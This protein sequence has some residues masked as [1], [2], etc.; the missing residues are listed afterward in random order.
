MKIQWDMS[1]FIMHDIAKKAT[2]CYIDE[3]KRKA[4]IFFFS[5]SSSL[6][7]NH[8]FLMSVINLMYFKLNNIIKCLK[9]YHF[10][11]LPCLFH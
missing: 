7:E 8:V 10:A 6:I 11:K 9:Q 1:I 2:R 5:S 4:K 3:S